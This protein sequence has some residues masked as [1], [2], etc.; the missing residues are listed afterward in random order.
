MN[1]LSVL[2]ETVIAGMPM[3]QFA[4]YCERSVPLTVLMMACVI[5]MVV[6]LLRSDV[7]NRFVLSLMA[8]FSMLGMA[9][10]MIRMATIHGISRPGSMY[11]VS[12]SLYTSWNAVGVF[13]C[14]VLMAVASV[15]GAKVANHYA[16]RRAKA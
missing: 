9:F 16:M 11:E 12:Q 15:L 13:F 5:G 4:E 14:G 6:I 1:Q 3:G 8:G 10:F 7:F 2:G